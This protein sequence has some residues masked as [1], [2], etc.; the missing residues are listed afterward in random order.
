MALINPEFAYYA[1]LR[2]PFPP[3]YLERFLTHLGDEIIIENNE[4]SAL[5]SAQFTFQ[6]ICAAKSQIFVLTLLK[7]IFGHTFSSIRLFCLHAEVQLGI[8]DWL[9]SLWHLLPPKEVAEL[10]QRVDEFGNLDLVPPMRLHLA[11]QLLFDDL[12]MRLGDATASNRGTQ[13]LLK[14]WAHSEAGQEYFNTPVTI[15]EGDP[16]FEEFFKRFSKLVSSRANVEGDIEIEFD[17]I[18]ENEAKIQDEDAMEVYEITPLK[19]TP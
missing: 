8:V 5:S 10:F 19:P 12:R 1:R 18:N 15:P 13:Q 6:F 2:P 14:A 9:H 11:S 3:T 7:C 17:D 16:S 4:R